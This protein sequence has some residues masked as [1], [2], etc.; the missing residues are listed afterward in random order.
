VRQERVRLALDRV[1]ERR[2]GPRGVSRLRG[3]D[4]AVD[5]GLEVIRVDRQDLLEVAGRPLELAAREKRL[6]QVETELDVG[7]V[8]PE[9]LLEHPDPAVG[10]E[11]QDRKL[12]LAQ[13]AQEPIAVGPGEARD[14]AVAA[15][16]EPVLLLDGL[17]PLVHL[18]FPEVDDLLRANR[19]AAL[20]GFLQGQDPRVRDEE[21]LLEIPHGLEQGLHGL[22]RALDHV[23]ERRDPLQQMLI[24]GD[25]LLGLPRLFDHSDAREHEQLRVAAGAELLVFGILQAADL[26]IHQAGYS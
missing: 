19:A 13:L 18:G 9:Q 17:H 20:E 10:V 14:D 2:L 26:A 25:L 21:V 7:A 3:R 11:G 16:E 22:G 4:A 15:L 24:E 1:V 8:G 23:L 5:E 6:G 12:R